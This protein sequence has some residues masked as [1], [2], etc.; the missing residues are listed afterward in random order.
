[1]NM[2]QWEH[3][4]SRI[5]FEGNGNLPCSL[6]WLLV[7]GSAVKS[8]VQPSLP[9]REAPTFLDYE[10]SSFHTGS[11]SFIL[12]SRCYFSIAPGWKQSLL[13]QV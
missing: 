9:P 4:H 2:V 6:K 11:S 8:A 12:V 10:L 3:S 7:S 5:R 1:M 13:E